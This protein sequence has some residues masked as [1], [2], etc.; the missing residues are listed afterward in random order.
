MIL[1]LLPRLWNGGT[2]GRPD[3]VI[4]TRIATSRSIVMVGLGTTT[5]AAGC[6]EDPLVKFTNV[7]T[8]RSSV[9]R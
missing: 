4:A 1:S 6:Y 9:K 2:A 7:D 8:M 5:C 3:D